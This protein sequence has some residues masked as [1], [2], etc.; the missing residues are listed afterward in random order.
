MGYKT[1]VMKS[2]DIYTGCAS[3]RITDQMDILLYVW[4]Y[5]KCKMIKKYLLEKL[6]KNLL[7]QAGFRSV[8]RD[9]ANW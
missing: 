6:S 8:K 7:N 4:E 5:I 1:E 3:D 2:Y 9:Y